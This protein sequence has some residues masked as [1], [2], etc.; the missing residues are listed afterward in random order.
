MSPSPLRLW[1]A[2]APGARGNQ[3]ADIPTLTVFAPDPSHRT[4]AAIIVFPGGGYGFLAPHEGEGYA[5]WLAGL[6]VTAFVLKYRLGSDGYRHPAMWQDA[7]RAVRLVRHL[8]A[9][10]PVDP[11]RI[12]VIGSS[13]GG[14][15]AATIMTTFDSGDAASPDPVER[16]SCR[17]DLGILCYPVITLRDPHVHAGS[18]QHLLGPEPSAAQIDALSADLR[19]TPDTPPAFIWHTVADAGVPVENSLLF[20]AALRRAGVPFAMSLFE[21]GEHGLGLG[22][23]DRPAPPWADACAYWLRSHRFL[24]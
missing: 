24:R 5:R 13:A 3:P 23:A 9:E 6:G 21:T 22:T 7:A 18:R 16:H 10:Y 8:A 2:A 4:G 19:V 12:G 15:L 17:P 1:P 20:A 11:G 14:H